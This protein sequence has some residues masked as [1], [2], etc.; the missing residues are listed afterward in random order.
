MKQE[1]L[2]CVLAAVTFSGLFTGWCVRMLRNRKNPSKS[3]LHEIA[4]IANQIDS[5]NWTRPEST[6]FVQ[7]RIESTLETLMENGRMDDDATTRVSSPVWI[8]GIKSTATWTC[9]RTRTSRSTVWPPESSPW[10]ITTNSIDRKFS[11]EKC[12]ECRTIG[13]Q[14]APTLCPIVSTRNNSLLLT[15]GWIRRN[16][17]PQVNE[18]G[19][20]EGSYKLR[21]ILDRLN[22]L[23]FLS[24]DVIRLISIYKKLWKITNF[25]SYFTECNF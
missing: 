15:T 12:P 18:M 11:N 13:L 24:F 10:W 6:N 17:I 16:P 2:Y 20:W 4:G 8:G 21:N 25:V 7:R 9:W 22:C 1:S 19:T 23:Y 14:T 5:Q 3:E